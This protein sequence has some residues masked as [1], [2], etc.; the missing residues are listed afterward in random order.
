[1]AMTIE[2]TANAGLQRVAAPS[3]PEARTVNASGSSMV[4]IIVSWGDAILH[5]AHL[6][7]TQRF[8]VGELDRSGRKSF[9]STW[10]GGKVDFLIDAAVLGA[11]CLPLVLNEDG[12]LWF[13][14]PR[15]AQGELEL[16][17]GRIGFDELEA[18][19]LLQPVSEAL[20]ASAGAH[21]HPLARGARAHIDVG[22]VRFSVRWV[23]AA[24]PVGFEDRSAASWSGRGWIL[25]SAAIHAALLAILH[26]LPAEPRVLERVPMANADDSR[27][28]ETWRTRGG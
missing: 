2:S 9:R 28:S 3:L 19:G 27:A 18:Q 11:Q 10:S 24:Q 4:E 22:T 16:A 25:A 14:I 23:A 20:I 17:G 15:G 12:K 13:V 8:W 6:A 7:P 1:M 5:V 21:K 26:W